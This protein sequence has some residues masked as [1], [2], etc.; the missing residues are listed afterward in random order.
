MYVVSRGVTARTLL[1]LALAFSG[2]GNRTFT[3]SIGDTTLARANSSGNHVTLPSDSSR[4]ANGAQVIVATV[5]D[6]TSH[7]GVGTRTG[8]IQ[9]GLLAARGPGM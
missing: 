1:L 4:V 7:I 9:N 3:L 2:S 8:N 5:R 6:A